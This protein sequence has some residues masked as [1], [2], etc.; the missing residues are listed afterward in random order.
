MLHALHT[1]FGGMVVHEY[2]GDKQCHV[3]LPKILP[4]TDA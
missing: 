2:I 1:V 4:R 3:S